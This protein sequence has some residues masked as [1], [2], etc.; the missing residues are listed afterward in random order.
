VSEPDILDS[1]AAGG[2]VVRGG[3]ARAAGY[4]AGTLLSLASFALITRH[5]GVERFG[6]YQTALSVI[7]VVSAITDAGM[8]TLAVREYATLDGAT[9]DRLMRNLLG[10][11]IG[12]TAAGVVVA[13]LCSSRSSPGSTA[14]SS[15]ARRSPG[16]GSAST[17][18]SPCSPCR[19]PRSCR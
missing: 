14:R 12:L 19:S 3:A 16:S 6:D 11:R 18:S 4:V 7:T 17:S 9:R 5:L 8:A 2:L 10:A 15:P 13:V 1:R